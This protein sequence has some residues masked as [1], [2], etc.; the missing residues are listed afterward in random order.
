MNFREHI[1]VRKQ[2]TSS[3]KASNQIERGRYEFYQLICLLSCFCFVLCLTGS[4]KT[5]KA[6]AQGML[7]MINQSQ[8]HKISSLINSHVMKPNSFSGDG[9]LIFV[10]VSL[11]YFSFFGH[12]LHLSIRG[13]KKFDIL[14]KA[15]FELDFSYLSN[16]HSLVFG[17]S[18]FN[19]FPRFSLWDYTYPTLSPPPSS[20]AMRF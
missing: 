5:K 15:W 9:T 7:K 11:F 17:C 19:T 4:A 10:S 1:Q 2:K 13:R 12:P 3:R 14:L 6:F 18:Y 8:M 16:F 20:S